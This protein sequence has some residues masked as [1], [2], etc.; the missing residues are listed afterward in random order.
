MIDKII[1]FILP[2]TL[3]QESGGPGGYGPIRRK[4]LKLSR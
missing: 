3:K 4:G 2:R 1:S